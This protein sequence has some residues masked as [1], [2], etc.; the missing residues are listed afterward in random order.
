MEQANVLK[1]E[2]SKLTKL[3]FNDHEHTTDFSF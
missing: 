3:S 1:V 2:K